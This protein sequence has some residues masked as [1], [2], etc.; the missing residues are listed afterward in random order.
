MTSGGEEDGDPDLTQSRGPVVVLQA[1][2]RV[3]L[4]GA[5]H[6]PVH[7]GAEAREGVLDFLGPGVESA[8][9]ALVVRHHRRLVLLGV[10]RSRL[11]VSVHGLL[12][13]G[14]KRPPQAARVL[15]PA[16]DAEGRAG[17]HEGPDPRRLRQHVVH[18]QLSSPRMA[19]EV[20]HI[21]AESLPDLGQFGDEALR[22]PEGGIGRPLG[23]RGAE[24]V[25]EHDRPLVGK[26]LEP[27]EVVAREPGTA[28]EDQKGSCGTPPCHPIPDLPAGNGP[29]DVRPLAGAF[30]LPDGVLA[31]HRVTPAQ[32]LQRFHAVRPLPSVVPVHVFG[33]LAEEPPRRIDGVNAANTRF[34][35]TAPTWGFPCSRRRRRGTARARTRIEPSPSGPRPPG[36]AGPGGRPSTRP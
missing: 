22:L 32:P 30:E 4:A 27:R 36:R 28:M 31:G 3:E 25:V 19:E 29:E 7:G 24:L 17:Q 18:G 21:E 20:N 1:P 8:D 15:D 33:E 5:P 12:R 9:V 11:L 13:L 14:R 6:G 23:S 16:R 2:G 34:A 26:V 10:G 35:R